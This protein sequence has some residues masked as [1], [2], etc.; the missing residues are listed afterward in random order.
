MADLLASFR[1]LLPLPARMEPGLRGVLQDLLEHPGSL[2]R[3][4]L[5]LAVMGAVTETVA[6]DARRG[7]DGPDPAA[8]RERAHKLAIAVE[9]FHTASLVFDDL[10]SMDDASERRGRPCPHRTHGEA[11]A[12]LGALALI[13]RAYA[14]LWEV[15]GTLAADQRTRAGSLVGDC[16]GA[17]GILDGQARDLRFAEA[18]D[19]RGA[20]L[21]L[22]PE[23]EVDPEAEPDRGTRVLRVAEGKTVQLVRLSLVLPALAA[24]AGDGALDRLEELSRAW[25]LAYQVLD[26]FKDGLMSRAETGKSTARDGVLGRPN[27]PA[28]I[29][30][31]AALVTLER[32]IQDARTA[33]DALAEEGVATARLE[34]LQRFLETERRTV[35]RRLHR[36]AGPARG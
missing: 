33:L 1:T 16:L 36:Y 22:R 34:R 24:G 18:D 3:A 6:G 14:L 26:D 25:G 29:G 35:S 15:L 11:P 8:T 30:E 20:E 2:A 12:T 31:E 4:Q 13:T 17:E 21:D 7:E 5:V 9:Y 27:L 23:G 32:L 19:T 10:P 28:A